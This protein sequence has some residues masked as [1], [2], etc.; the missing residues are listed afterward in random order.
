MLANLKQSKSSNLLDFAKACRLLKKEWGFKEMSN[1]FKISQYMLRQIDKINEL[2]P[3][4]Q[5][6][7]KVGKLKIETSYQLWRIPESQREK[8]A[9][10]IQGLSSNQTRDF[11][12]YAIKYQ[13]D[14]DK[15]E[16][17][18][19]KTKDKKIRLLVLPLTDKIYDDLKISSKKSKKN[20]H[21][22]AL[23]ILE[24]YLYGKKK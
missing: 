17:K 12:H 15:A 19:E 22:H 5:E 23:K 16:K 4:L 11:I 24:N 3:S 18:F 20:V 7:V 6:L 8:A 9:K 14:L 2:S 21:D 13:Y 1:Y 10:I